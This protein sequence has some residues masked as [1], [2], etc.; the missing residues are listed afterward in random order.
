M[1]EQQYKIMRANPLPT[2]TLA[3]IPYRNKT[4]TVAFPAFGPNY[5][6]K[7]IKN[8]QGVYFHPKTRKKISFREPTTAESIAVAS[9]AFKNMKR[10]PEF[11]YVKKEIF[12]PKWLQ[13]GRILKTSEGIYVNPPKSEKG[14]VLTDDRKLKE[15]LT[16]KAKKNNIYLMENDFAFAP[17]ES[18]KHDVQDSGDFVEGGLARALEYTKEK[19]AK[20][21][22]AIVNPKVFNLG[23]NVFGFEQVKEPTITVA[24]LSSNKCS[25]DEW[26]DEGLDVGG[27][28]WDINEGCVFG[29]LSQAAYLFLNIYV[30]NIFKSKSHSNFK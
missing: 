24:T 25:D 12:N 28:G 16:Q 11:V 23:V 29:V 2:K 19:K 3:E 4:L 13:I 22:E 1:T 15:Y 27:Y 10:A 5:F 6:S 26:L 30:T 18:F 8:M 14:E 17:Y 20:M 7:N 21:L 9:F